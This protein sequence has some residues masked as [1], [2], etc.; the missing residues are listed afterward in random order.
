MKPPM[1]IVKQL[2]AR[3]LSLKDVSFVESEGEIDQRFDLVVMKPRQFGPFRAFL[4]PRF[5]YRSNHHGSQIR[6]DREL[7]VGV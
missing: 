1:A 3:P 6:H 7:H 5:V 4:I 2:T